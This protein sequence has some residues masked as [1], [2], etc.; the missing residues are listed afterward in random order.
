[1]RHIA[2]L[3]S[4]LVFVPTLWAQTP[5]TITGV[6]IDSTGA[7]LPRATVRLLDKTG[8]EIAKNLTDSD[9]RFQFGGTTSGSYRV[10]AS[11]TGFRPKIAPAEA[12]NELHIV[13]D[14]A[15]VREYVTV[16]AD[17]TQTPTSLTGAATTVLDQQAIADRQQ[18]LVSSVLQSAPGVMVARTGGLGNVTSVFVRGGESNYNKILLDGVPLNE[19]G[20]TF[21]FSNLAE[22]D[23]DRIEIVRGPQSALFGS[24]AMASTIQ[25]FTHRGNPEGIR[26]RISLGFDAG[27]FQTLH[28]R[29]GLSG[30]YRRLDYALG[31]SRLETDNQ[32]PHNAF[33]NSTLS[34]NFGL[35]LGKNTAARLILRGDF[36]RVGTPGA[37]AFERPDN[38]AFFRKADGYAG[39]ALH[40]R[41]SEKWNQSFT[42]TFART[43]QVSRDLFIDPPYTPTFEGHKAPFQF[44]DFP[45]DFL[46]DAKREHIGYQSDVT[47]GSVTRAGGQHLVTLAFDWDGERAFLDDRLNSPTLPTRAERNNFGG[48][49][50]DQAIW[51]RLALTNGFRV[52][53]NGSFG[54]TVVPRSSASYLIRQHGQTFGATRLKFNFGLGIKEPTFTQSFSPSPSFAG[55]PNLRPERARS[56]DYGIEQRLFGDR[57][58]LE[59]NGFNNLFRELIASQTTSF[60]PFRSTFFNIA[61]SRADGA[62]IIVELAPRK[63]WRF[64]ANYTFLQGVIER[65]SRP[66]SPVFRQGQELFRRPKHL[67]SVFAA[68][69]WRQFTLTSNAIFVGKRVDSDFSSLVPPI[70]SDPSYTKWNIGWNYRSGY[71]VTYFGIFENV[72]NQ[73]YMEALGFPALRASYRAGARLTF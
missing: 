8:D 4:F 24:D 60:T 15:P 48:T 38:D 11:L 67:G 32:E 22:E 9:G 50:Q 63:G 33:D 27:K 49:F 52:E 34:S 16:T 71:R 54:R 39:F 59:L 12:G 70:I 69:D 30:G 20:G 23:L 47:L 55:N 45:F 31:W 43:R 42:Y 40:N 10:E 57:A 19:P 62:E 66:T 21:E 2:L 37:T 6:L 28:G 18:L 26:P 68:W 65:S 51:G 3:C 44:S 64:G 5:S 41:T 36:G 1:M 13:L 7:V 73:R 17:R 46:N 25:F 56:F 29:A 35:G 53:D 72:L 61:R 14:V 58:K